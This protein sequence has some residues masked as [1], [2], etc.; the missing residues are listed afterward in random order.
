MSPDGMNL[1]PAYVLQCSHDEHA[2]TGS[3]R[4]SQDDTG[5][6]VAVTD[7]AAMWF[8]VPGGSLCGSGQS[9][10]SENVAV[11]TRFL[12]TDRRV[13]QRIVAGSHSAICGKIISRM[14]V[15]TNAS[16]RMLVPL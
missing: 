12:Q 4:P 13:R 7:I 5:H 6:V 9:S 11:V 3:R 16:I 15:A 14:V 2:G 1:S 10:R 8:D